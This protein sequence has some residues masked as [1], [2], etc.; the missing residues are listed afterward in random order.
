MKKELLINY[1]CLTYASKMSFNYIVYL[2]TRPGVEPVAPLDG[3]QMI[4][5][6]GIFFQSLSDY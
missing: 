5:S 2:L 6:R 1:K 3:F 4:F